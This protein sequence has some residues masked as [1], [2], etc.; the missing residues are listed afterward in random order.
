MAI[1]GFPALNN[2]ERFFEASWVHQASGDVVC[3]I[4]VPAASDIRH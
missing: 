4:K 2:S 3:E 1:R